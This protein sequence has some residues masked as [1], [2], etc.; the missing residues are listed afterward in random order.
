MAE[1]TTFSAAEAA[2]YDRQMR[3]WGVEAQKRLQN[4]RVLVS[5]FSALG[6]ELVKNL[7]LA[8]MGVTLHDD[9]LTN[10]ANGSTQFF[11]SVEDVG[12]NRAEACLAQVQELNPLV[13]VSCETKPLSALPDAFF[14]KFTVVCLVGAD[15][16]SELRLDQL[17]RSFG[18]A[19][20]AARSFGFDG[21]M[22]AD[23]GAHTFRRNPI[24]ADM[25]PS[26]PITMIFP[27]LEEAQKVQ[28]SSLQSA[29]KRAPQLPQVFV[30][31][32]LLQGYKT[33]KNVTSIES[34]HVVDFIQFARAQFEAQGLDENYLSPDELQTLVR[35]V[36]TDLVPICAIVAGIM[37]QEVI[38]AISQKD[39]PICNY[40][41]FDGVTGTVRRIG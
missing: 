37:G 18:T 32:Q 34:E 41:C 24:G 14:K 15:Q 39:E 13:Q 20:F 3:L 2:V 40:F 7:V 29:R 4:S 11:L 8:G 21:I 36:D 35:V 10:S 5:G 25:A 16:S 6:S 33:E 22:F 38:K 17:C 19:F 27:T 23:L 30:K 9:Q 28:W 12:K 31:N 26:D 1:Q